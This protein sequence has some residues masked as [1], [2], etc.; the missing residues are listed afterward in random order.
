MYGHVSLQLLYDLMDNFKLTLYRNEFAQFVG[1]E[2]VKFFDF[3]GDSLDVALRKFLDK[4]TLAGE[5]Q[6]RERVL[7]HFSRRYTDCNPNVFN[8][9]GVLC[10]YLSQHVLM[11]LHVTELVSFTKSGYHYC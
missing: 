10:N 9:S 6:E 2:F 8:S 11:R 5:T 4:I 1:E 7:G 3:S